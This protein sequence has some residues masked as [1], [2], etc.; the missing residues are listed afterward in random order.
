MR[1]GVSDRQHRAGHARN[2]NPLGGG[3]RS[4]P[5]ASGT[6]DRAW[7]QELPA[8]TLAS[9]GRRW[10]AQ[11]SS[12]GGPR[13]CGVAAKTRHRGLMALGGSSRGHCHTGTQQGLRMAERRHFDAS[14]DLGDRDAHRVAGQPAGHDPS[15]HHPAGPPAGARSALGWTTAARPTDSSIGWTTRI[16]PSGY[17][18]PATDATRAPQYN[19][20]WQI[21]LRRLD[22]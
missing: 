21:R 16:A 9:P 19:T 6:A 4:W 8:L 14:G 15:L 10:M 20:G 5:A 18:S 2:T 1:L 22:V 17:G 13:P 7:L 12:A 3:P 11:H